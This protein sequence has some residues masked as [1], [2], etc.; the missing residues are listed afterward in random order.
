MRKLARTA[1]LAG[2]ALLGIGLAAGAANAAGS[3]KKTVVLEVGGQSG[4]AAVAYAVSNSDAAQNTDTT[5]TAPWSKTVIS[6]DSTVKVTLT[7][8]PTGGGKVTCKITI[9]GAVVA[10]GSASGRTS[11]ATCTAN[12]GQASQGWNGQGW[13]GQGWNGQGWNGQGWNGRGWNGHGSDWWS[14]TGFGR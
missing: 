11:Q 12:Q 7:A 5:V 3:S 10:S 13:N 9:D 4:Q 14:W 1:A 2:V 6:S 8:R